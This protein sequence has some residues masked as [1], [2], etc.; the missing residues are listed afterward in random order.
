M[1]HDYRIQASKHLKDFQEFTFWGTRKEM[2]E[3]VDALLRAGFTEVVC[4][5]IIL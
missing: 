5:R 4:V 1:K 3:Q 2:L